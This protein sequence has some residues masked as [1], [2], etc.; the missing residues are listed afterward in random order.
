[1]IFGWIGL[2]R[3]IGVSSQMLSKWMKLYKFPQP[4]PGRVKSWD[5]RAVIVWMRDNKEIVDIGVY[6][7]R[8]LRIRRYRNDQ[9][10]TVS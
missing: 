7:S 4:I 6:N 10:E 8:T 2:A 9:Q 3:F 5:L 1:M